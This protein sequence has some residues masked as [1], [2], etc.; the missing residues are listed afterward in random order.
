MGVL[1]VKRVWH[2]LVCACMNVDAFHKVAWWCR[3]VTV[4]EDAAASVKET[5]MEIASHMP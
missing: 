4:L 3:C 2:M 1:C 5:V